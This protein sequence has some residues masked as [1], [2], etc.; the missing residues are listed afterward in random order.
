M[1]KGEP[2]RGK[3]TPPSLVVG[4]KSKKKK[5]NVWQK[6]DESGQKVRLQG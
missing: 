1:K 5:G 3:V 6:M 4:K 2:A